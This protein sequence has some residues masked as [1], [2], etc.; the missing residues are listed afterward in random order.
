[1]LCAEVVEGLG[2]AKHKL[3]PIFKFYAN[4]QN[5]VVSPEART[6]RPLP[7]V[8]T[9]LSA[10]SRPISPSAQRL[11]IEATP[12]LP[13]TAAPTTHAPAAAPAAAS[14][15]LTLPG[16]TTPSPQPFVRSNS[17]NQQQQQQQQPPQQP[18]P[19][20]RQFRASARNSS[21]QDAM[22]MEG[23]FSSSGMALA[24]AKSGA[25]LDNAA[26]QLQGMQ[27]SGGGGNS[28]R[29]TTAAS[30]KSAAS[31]QQV[32]RARAQMPL[33]TFLRFLQDFD[34]L[35]RLVNKSQA[36]ACFRAA[37]LGPGRDDDEGADVGR[38][39]F[40]EF[41]EAVGRTAL[42]AFNFQVR[43]GHTTWPCMRSW[44][45]KV[46]SARAARARAQRHVNVNHVA[47][48]SHVRRS[49]AS[50]RSS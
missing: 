42:I 4:E 38:I 22:T 33:P 49:R 29:P 47:N 3:R 34:V 14:T 19:P 7:T 24:A 43:G 32:T 46:L 25:L 45:P 5:I 28:T 12:Q 40:V 15:R 1:M 13:A 23:A 6:R 30:H 18:Q 48:S 50:P 41:V 26:R 21:G 35:P 17:A 10:L 2:Q 20:S 36:T 31:Q 37:R 39:D 16:S 8:A 44:P 9:T 27:A 11:D